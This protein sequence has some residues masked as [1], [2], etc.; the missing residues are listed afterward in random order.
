MIQIQYSMEEDNEAAVITINSEQDIEQGK[1]ISP[2][3]ARNSSRNISLGSIGYTN[4]YTHPTKLPVGRL[5]K[6]ESKVTHVSSLKRVGPLPHLSNM[7]YEIGRAIP[8]VPKPARMLELLQNENN[9][10]HHRDNNCRRDKFVSMPRRGVSL[11]VHRCQNSIKYEYQHQAKNNETCSLV[12]NNVSS[13][14]ASHDSSQMNMSRT[15]LSSSSSS[16]CT[17]SSVLSQEKELRLIRLKL[18]MSVEEEKENASTS[19]YGDSEI[20]QYDQD[21]KS[22]KEE[23]ENPWV[24][25]WDDEIESTYYYNVKTGEASWVSPDY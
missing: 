21:Y 23:E 3:P 10:M 8:I 18:W 14:S 25:Y 1:T 11:D 2:S 16:T 19:E 9:Y 5:G 15:S 17:L 7:H 22:N 4:S 20:I 13:S 6:E 24:E 12:D